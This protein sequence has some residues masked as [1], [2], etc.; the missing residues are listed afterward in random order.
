MSEVSKGSGGGAFAK[1]VQKT[2][3]RTRTKVNQASV[4]I[5]SLYQFE[6][7]SLITNTTLSD[8]E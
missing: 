3:A 4:D 5:I 6:A 2:L 1:V 7:H 8:N